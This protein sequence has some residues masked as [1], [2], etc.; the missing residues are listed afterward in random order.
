VVLEFIEI[1]RG[2]ANRHSWSPFEPSH[3][4]DAFDWWDRLPY[5]NDKPWYIQ[6]LRDESEVGR[7]ELDEKVGLRHYGVDRHLE[8]KALEIQFIEV[9]ADC[10]RQGIAT[11]IV[12]ELERRHPER[13]LVAFSE[14]ADDFWA[15]LGWRRYDHP[16]EAQFY[17]P[18]FVHQA[19]DNLNC[20]SGT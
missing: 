8:A 7:V 1:R 9:S 20:P 15:S 12:R 17:R 16:T 11:Q 10:R 2:G 19:A 5:W 6:I 13:T 4:F 14:Q 18:L 3:G